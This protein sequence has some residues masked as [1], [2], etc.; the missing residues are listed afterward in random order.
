MHLLLVEDDKRLAR[1]LTRL[2]ARFRGKL[3][4]LLEES[5]DFPGLAPKEPVAERLGIIELFHGHHRAHAAFQPDYGNALDL[6]ASA[7]GHRFRVHRFKFRRHLEH[8][9]GPD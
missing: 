1:A 2:L 6:R 7:V 4:E 5:G 8:L 3:P 9:A